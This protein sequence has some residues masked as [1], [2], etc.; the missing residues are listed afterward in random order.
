MVFQ[1]VYDL[2]TR[3]MK[4]VESLA[5][6][7]LLPV[8]SPDVWFAL[9]DRVGLGPELELRAITQALTAL[10]HLPPPL[11]LGINI[12]PATVYSARLQEELE[13]LDLTR[14]VLEI[15]EH[16]TVTDYKELAIALA[17]MRARGLRVAVD[18]TGAG[19]ASMRHILNIDPSMIKLDKSLTH[20]IDID[21]RRRA[22]AKGLIAFA[23]EI[24]CSISAEGVETASE[25]AMLK[26]L[27][28][29]MAQGFYLDRPLPLAGV[30]NRL[31]RAPVDTRPVQ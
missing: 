11:F 23:H 12:S 30:L 15:T 14:I 1:P 16:V 20:D 4:G 9:A 13:T 5:R 28:V 8:R 7:D 6:F 3:Q 24:G 26:A 27:G 31:S 19:F 21:D 22:L 17:P 18:D 29:D 2:G 10:D 25:L